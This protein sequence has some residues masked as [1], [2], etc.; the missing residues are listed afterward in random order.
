M[1]ENYLNF[2]TSLKCVESEICSSWLNCLIL[3][4]GLNVNIIKNVD[5]YVYVHCFYFNYYI[6]KYQN[7]TSR[8][9]CSYLNK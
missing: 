2:M 1:G 4:S 3:F 9:L 5:K 8:K 7:I 6:T